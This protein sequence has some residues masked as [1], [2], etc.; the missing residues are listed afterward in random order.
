VDTYRELHLEVFRQIAG[1]VAVIVEK[2]YLHQELQELSDTKNRFLGMVAHDLRYPLSL[3][4]A[5][6]DLFLDGSMGDLAP[7]QLALLRIIAGHQERLLEQVN[8]VLDM[9][10]IA[11]GHLD[12]NLELVDSH[13][14][15]S[16]LLEAFEVA[17]RSRSLDLRVVHAKGI[18]PV[19]MDLYRIRQV[20]ANLMAN[21][22]QTSQP[23]SAIVLS[24]SRD[25]R[26]LKIRITH[27]GRDISPHE[28]PSLFTHH[29][30]DRPGPKS[31][32]GMGFAIAQGIVEAHGGSIRAENQGGAGTTL[33]VAL[34]LDGS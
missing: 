14:L 12:L 33:T 15:L 4:S 6:L 2:G 18:P 34:P 23:G 22:I 20:L 17:A 29:D 24:T 5:Y 25:G 28:V 19:R 30:A 27:H 3:S 1:Q 13:S 11:A 10:T 9:S 31:S 32:S 21:T 7:D 26:F 8:K 16:E